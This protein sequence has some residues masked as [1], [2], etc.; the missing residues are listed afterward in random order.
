M[1]YFWIREWNR[2]LENCVGI[3]PEEGPEERQNAN[4]FDFGAQFR[5]GVIDPNGESRHLIQIGHVSQRDEA[6]RWRFDG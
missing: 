6:F 5:G 3:R 2:K 4:R 1:A